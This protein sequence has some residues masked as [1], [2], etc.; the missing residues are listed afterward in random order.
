MYKRQTGNST[1]FGD[2]VTAGFYCFGTSNKTRGIFQGRLT[3]APTSGDPMIDSVII[4]ST[5]NAVEFG[6][7]YRMDSGPADGQAIRRRGATTVSDSHGG[8]S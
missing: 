4:A 7:M 5:G 3:T 2:L 8:L 1:D 6:E